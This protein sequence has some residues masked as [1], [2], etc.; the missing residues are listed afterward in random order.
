MTPWIRAFLWIL[1]AA[2]VA[3]LTPSAN[4]DE[5]KSDLW[6]ISGQS[7][8]E[9]CGKL[10]G[11]D[12]NPKVEMLDP[13][14]LKW[15]TATEPLLMLN[16]P[17]VGAWHAAALK[18]AEAGFSV[19]L[20][21]WAAAGVPIT[22]WDDGA[23][24]WKYLSL[25]IKKSGEG[26]STFFWYQGESDAIQGGDAIKNYGAHLKELAGKVRALAK[27]PQMLIVVVQIVWDGAPDG[28]MAIREAQRQFVIA[29][30]NAILV[31]SL[32]MK[33]DGG[34]LAREGYLELGQQIGRALLKFRYKDKKA[35]W[36]GPVMDTAVLGSDAK[37]AAVHFAEVKK[38]SGCKADDFGAVDA[39]G[40][41][42]CT[43]AE[44]QN[45]RVV[46]TFERAITLPAKLIYGYGPGPKAT[47]EDEDGNHAPAVQLDLI[48]GP[49]PV[50]SETTAPNGAGS[51]K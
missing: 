26:A 4:A 11:L 34:H 19:R 8:A 42:K 44:A 33:G 32:G 14:K 35:N 30:G 27:N 45:T 6:I 21:G 20:T 36:P 5:A 17:G 7:N 37:L 51:K 40:K 10:P 50:D 2:C 18:V 48:I 16:S 13:R 24:G 28:A 38:L 15:E 23:E 29:D 46:L 47:L 9:G 39:A 25:Y 43:K 1:C 31:T 22:F 3:Q 12:P 49:Q 41:V